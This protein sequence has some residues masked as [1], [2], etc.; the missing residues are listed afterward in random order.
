MKYDTRKYNVH[1]KPSLF[2][3]GAAT[4]ELIIT[5]M[6]AAQRLKRAKLQRTQTRRLITRGLSTLNSVDSTEEISQLICKFEEYLQ[7]L[8]KYDNE[9]TECLCL[10]DDEDDSKVGGD[11][12]EEEITKSADIRDEVTG[13][14]A[15]LKFRLQQCSFSSPPSGKAPRAHDH[16]DNVGTL[17]PKM[18]IV[19]I[20]IFSGD[21]LL[22]PTFWDSFRANVHENTHYSK[23][24]KMSYLLDHLK[25]EAQSALRHFQITDACYDEAI[26]VLKE[27]FGREQEVKFAH[28]LELLNLQPAT[29]QSELRDV[30]DKI[31]GHL[32]C[33]STLGFDEDDNAVS[34][35]PHEGANRTNSVKRQQRLESC[36][37]SS[38]PF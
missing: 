10:L 13:A 30:V 34:E 17:G 23:V 11:T 16:C 6:N 20:P 26:E 27:R 4:R 8:D 14:L 32:R 5:K 21:L 1:H 35:N 9:I 29:K 3:H 12:L 28:M 22:W 25:G 31:E 18:P 15:I 37:P 36:R 24:A 7:Q 2:S 19:K 38:P 33:L